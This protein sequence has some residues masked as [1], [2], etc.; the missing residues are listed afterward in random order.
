MP[1]NA[2]STTQTTP[3]SNRVNFAGYFEKTGSNAWGATTSQAATINSVN[4]SGQNIVVNWTGTILEAQ[5][6]LGG[7]WTTVST[8]PGTYVAPIGSGQN[9]FRAR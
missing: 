5:A 8:T 3:G 9:Y 4:T 7:A 1:S 6:F 2:Y